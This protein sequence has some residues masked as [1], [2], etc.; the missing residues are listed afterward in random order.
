MQRHA[1]ILD[2]RPRS[3]WDH[4]IDE[5]IYSERDR[6]ILRRKLLDGVT[7][8]QIFDELGE[9]LHPRQIKRRFY[10]AEEQLFRH[11]KIAPK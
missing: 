4:L 8:D 9:R 6:Y 10:A 7:F 2:Q 11:A 3:E 1:D 5:W